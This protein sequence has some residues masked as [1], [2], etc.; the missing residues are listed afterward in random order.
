MELLDQWPVPSKDLLA[1]QVE[2]LQGT[3][4]GAHPFAPVLRSKGFTWCTSEP[5]N[6]VEWVHA[7][8]H[9]GMSDEGR[10]WSTYSDAELREFLDAAEMEEVKKEFEGEFGDC[11]NELVFIGIDLNK[12]AIRSEM[13]R[14]LVTDEEL[15]N[16]LVEIKK[17]EIGQGLGWGSAAASGI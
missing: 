1:D 5:F 3:E 9:L 12:D 17:S 4:S 13:E 14:C 6:R 15:E 2:A 16:F 8:K 10:W 7:G 11:R